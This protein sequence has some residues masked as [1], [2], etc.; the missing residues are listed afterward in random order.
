MAIVTGMPTNDDEKPSRIEPLGAG[1]DFTDPNSPLAPYYVRN[2]SVVGVLLLALAVTFFGTL[3]LW[4]SDIWG[5]VLFGQWMI[6]HGKLPDR[7]PFTP[8]S[9]PDEKPVHAQW[10]T[11]VLYGSLVK[12][13][14][15]A[16]SSDADP[17]HRLARQAEL[18]RFFHV[19][20]VAGQFT[21]L[22]LAFRRI[23]SPGWANLA[24][25]LLWFQMLGPHTVQRPQTVGLL[26]FSIQLFALSRP[27]FSH[28]AAWLLPLLYL[29]WA[30]LHGTFAVG[31]AFLYLFLGMT[32][33]VT[34]RRRGSWGQAFHD[35]SLRRLTLAAVLSVLA[36]SVNPHGPMLYVEIAKF[37]A[38]PN[39]DLIDEWQPLTAEL[40]DGRV[41]NRYLTLSGIIL[42][43]WLL[44]GCR[45][46]E[47]LLLCLP[48]ALWPLKQQ[49]M[50]VWWSMLMPWLLA[51]FGP[52]LSQRL[53]LN[54]LPV[55]V[56]SFRKTILAGSIVI[57]GFVWI[58]VAQ[59]MNKGAV[60]PLERVISNGTAA[61]IGFE[62]HATPQQKGRW[63][64][65]FDK[66]IRGYPDGRFQGAIFSSEV[67]GDYLLRVAPTG[68]PVLTYSHAHYFPREF[69]LDC[70]KVK[71]AA[72]GWQDFLRRYH[73]NLIVIQP[74]YYDRFVQALRDDPDWIVVQDDPAATARGAGDRLFIALRKQ[75]V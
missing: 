44:S 48:F 73:V 19:I 54:R 63:L 71:F 59:S 53:M 67:L 41:L 35:V 18:L 25:I 74:D 1:I 70:L 60:R 64:P 58:G 3:R 5:H 62:F 9:D 30:N 6:D 23:G 49:R 21:F 45:R 42:G 29:A 17:E 72:D 10:L 43:G 4:H 66:A 46:T 52:G 20:V 16:Y 33:I 36:V 40:E 31:L 56:P 8:F 50:M 61:K 65:A 39:I 15:S 75:P 38:R 7:E 68:S 11:Q 34:R 57:L 51:S 14:E 2:A 27:E 26:C 47:L 55:S 22:W 12:L 28:R 69:W 32:I 24:L 13:G 37:A